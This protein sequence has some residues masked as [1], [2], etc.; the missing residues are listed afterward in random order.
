MIFLAAEL[1]ETTRLRIAGAQ[2]ARGRLSRCSRLATTPAQ[3][4]WNLYGSKAQFRQETTSRDC[5][6]AGT[7]GSQRVEFSMLDAILI[8]A[9]F[10]FFA[11]AIAYAFACDRL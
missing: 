11:A 10:A 9:G 6:P 1:K 2:I 4:I 3:F 7:S 5:R 8:A